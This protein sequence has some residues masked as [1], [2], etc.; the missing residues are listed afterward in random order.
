[1]AEIYNVFLIGPCFFKRSISKKSCATGWKTM[2]WAIVVIRV[3]AKLS[4]LN[5]TVW[6]QIEDTR[7]PRN[8]DHSTD[9][10]AR[11]F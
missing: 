11:W 7:T 2:R 9:Y 1:M 8:I 6:R 4:L 3:K 10:A 5:R